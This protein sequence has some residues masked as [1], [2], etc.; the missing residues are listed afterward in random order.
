MNYNRGAHMS[1]STDGKKKKDRNKS[2]GIDYNGVEKLYT[3]AQ[4]SEILSIAEATFLR[5]ISQ[6]KMVVDI[7]FTGEGK[8]R[9][10]NKE[11]IKNI[12][13]DVMG[14]KL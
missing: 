8:H 3:L 1:K 6:G 9:R 7:H 10:F 14:H 11:H 4:L 2:S 13:R 5:Y 12:R